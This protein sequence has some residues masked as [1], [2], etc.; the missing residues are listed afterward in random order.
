[1]TKTRAE[2]VQSICDQ[3]HD[4]REGAIPRRTPE[5][6]E[7]WV[8]QFPDGVQDGILFEMDRLLDQTYISRKSMDAFLQGLTKNE[9]L[10]GA[11][12]EA[13]WKGANLLDIQKG[14]NSQSDMLEMFGGIFEK[15]FGS[16]IDRSG[17]KDGPFIY[18]DDAVFSGRRV[19]H[20]LS[21]WIEGIAPSKFTLHII[22]AVLYQ[23]G[24]YYVNK[25][26]AELEAKT[27]KKV[28][29]TWWRI[30]ELENRRY[31]KNASDV[32]WPTAAP[33]G[34]LGDAY[35]KYMTEQEPKYQVELRQSGSVGTKALFSSD[36]NRI[37]LEQQ[38][39]SAGLEI[40][41]KCPNLHESLRPL[42]SSSLKTF[43]F[44]S[45]L[46]TFRN[47]PNNCPLVYWVD[48]P[49][50]PLFPRSTNADASMKRLFGAFQAGR[51]AKA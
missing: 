42:G 5:V 21:G 29:V 36:Q 50:Y 20:D 45:T 7:R 14:G 9:K 27:G 10:C 17:S 34:P 25:R 6:V 22:A 35:V 32:Y 47:C 1:M 18:L 43:G 40:R 48:A 11:D 23:G 15:V 33:T 8:R 44:G 46:V 12:P 2:L 26:L 16:A 4:Y 37:L 31:Y 39:L 24:I 51:K 3:V 13:F 28:S 41:K 49:W 19:V 38:F 30:L